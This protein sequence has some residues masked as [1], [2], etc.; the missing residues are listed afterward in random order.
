MAT[1][2]SI[3]FYLDCEVD[4]ELLEELDID[5]TYEEDYVVLRLDLDEIL[6]DS[7]Q[8]DELLEFIGIDSEFLVYSE[9]LN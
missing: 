4:V 5:Y 2:V 9:V 3:A 8:T 1:K 7:L 6:V